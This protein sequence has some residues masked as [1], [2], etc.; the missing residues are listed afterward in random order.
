ML[1]LVLVILLIFGV[2]L[3]VGLIVRGGRGLG[4]V[5]ENC[6]WGLCCYDFILMLIVWILGTFA[7]SRVGC[8]LFNLKEGIISS[9]N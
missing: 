8:S 7:Y 9:L 1:R 2:G 6:K 3:V 4:L 5:V